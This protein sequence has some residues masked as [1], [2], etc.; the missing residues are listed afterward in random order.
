[1][2]YD[3]QQLWGYAEIAET[4]GEYRYTVEAVAERDNIVPIGTCRGSYCFS[5]DDARTIARGVKNLSKSDREQLRRD[6]LATLS[7]ELSQ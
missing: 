7:K 3:V 5:T 2:R 6:V 4:L 1:M